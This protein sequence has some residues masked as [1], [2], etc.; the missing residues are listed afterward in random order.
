[1]VTAINH[2]HHNFIPLHEL[3]YTIIYFISTKS[4]KVKLSHY[5]YAGDK[6][7]RSDHLILDLGTKWGSVVS[8]TLYPWYPLNR[9]LGGPQSY[10]RHRG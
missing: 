9:R 3:S 4:K 7:E 1:M 2:T 10:S 6:E 5:C 8:V